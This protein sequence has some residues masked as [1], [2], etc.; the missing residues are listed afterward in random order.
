MAGV[1]PV[2]K[3]TIDKNQEKM[4]KIVDQ[5]LTNQ[6]K[7]HF[8]KLKENNLISLEDALRFRFENNYT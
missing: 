4:D 6:S 8:R 3:N 1:E 5:K 2:L 7:E